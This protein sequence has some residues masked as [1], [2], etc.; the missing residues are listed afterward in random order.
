M[1][2]PGYSLRPGRDRV[3]VIAG[4]FTDRKGICVPPPLA[5]RHP[6]MPEDQEASYAEMQDRMAVYFL[7][8]YGTGWW[9]DLFQPGDSEMA[10]LFGKATNVRGSY[11]RYFARDELETI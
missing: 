2:D 4:P 7:T 1:I 8:T 3:L 11:I 6:N 10:Q 5:L 9:I